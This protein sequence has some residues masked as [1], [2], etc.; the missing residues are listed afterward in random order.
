MSL[1]AF[2]EHIGRQYDALC[3]A[4]SADDVIRICPPIQGTS[5]GEGFFEGS[6][7]DKQVVDALRIAGWKIVWIEAEYYW[8]ME[9]PDGSS[10]TYVEGDLHRGTGRH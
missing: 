6:G 8:A 7:G 10:V 1:D 5:V 2:W 4:K 9:A 3:K